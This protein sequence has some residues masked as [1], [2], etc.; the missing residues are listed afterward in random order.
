[1]RRTVLYVKIL[2]LEW[3]DKAEIVESLKCEI[4]YC[5]IE[6]VGKWEQLHWEIQRLFYFHYFLYISINTVHIKF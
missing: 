4:H 1:M 2:M 3:I 5:K 6:V